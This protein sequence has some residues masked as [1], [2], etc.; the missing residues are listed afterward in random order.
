MW[1]LCEASKTEALHES[2]ATYWATSSYRYRAGEAA[3]HLQRL[4]LRGLW[5]HTETREDMFS[6]ASGSIPVGSDGNH[7][8]SLASVNAARQPFCFKTWAFSLTGWFSVMPARPW[9]GSL[10]LALG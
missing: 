1:R 3:N 8:A 2:A 4:C 9:G 7:T 6:M 10:A 5:H